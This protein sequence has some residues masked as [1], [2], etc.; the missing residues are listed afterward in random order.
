MTSGT[1]LAERS[2]IS[3]TIRLRLPAH[4]VELRFC[5]IV[6]HT[7]MPPKDGT[8]TNTP[9]GDLIAQLPDPHRLSFVI[10]P[11]QNA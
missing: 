11:H 7:L 5:D 9:C 4:R 1:K 8:P 10:D 6:S 3:A 2:S